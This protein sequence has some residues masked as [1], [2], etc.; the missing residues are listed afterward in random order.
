M[1]EH[2]TERRRSGL[3]SGALLGVCLAVAGCIGWPRADSAYRGNGDAQI[4]AFM[5]GNHMSSEAGIA[6]HLARHL[7]SGLQPGQV[8]DRAYLLRRGALCTDATPGVCTF[9]GIA[10]VRFGGLPKENTRK[11]RQVTR[12]EARVHAHPTLTIEVSKET[13][14][15]DD[16]TR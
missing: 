7:E 11:A 9:S 5:Q 2:G 10:D 15:P 4:L 14:Y 16:S 12:I 1:K 8:I 6:R 3:R 13:T